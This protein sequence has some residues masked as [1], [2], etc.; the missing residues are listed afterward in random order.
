MAMVM[1]STSLS[2]AQE[3]LTFVSV[4]PPGT[5]TDVQIRTLAAAWEKTHGTGSS[6][7]LNRPGA[8]GLL[9]ARAVLEIAAKGQSVVYAPG[10]GHMTTLP[11]E[12]FSKLTALVEMTKQPMAI[13][14]RKTLPANTW[15][16]L[17]N[18][19]ETQPG[20]VSVGLASGAMQAMA[21][22]IERRNQ[23]RFNKIYYSTMG[24]GTLATTA[25]ASNSI[26]LFVV[27][28]AIGFFDSYLAVS[29][30]I[31]ITDSNIMPGVDAGLFVG[32]DPKIGHWGVRTGLFVSTSMDT[33]VKNHLNARLV[34]IIKSAEIRPKWESKGITIV[35]NR[36]VDEYQQSVTDAR[37]YWQKHKDIILK[38]YQQ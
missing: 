24:N 3:K 8:D 29:K 38:D 16:E 13:I 11:E 15:Q 36:S 37:Q 18:L 4:W 23:I 6:L 31:A 19:V 28:A 12:E 20:R 21:Y 14:A 34:E 25:L 22:E 27:P 10:S 32:G 30:I 2:L 26:D 17:K 7:V 1:L 33:K 35:A 5:G 9:A